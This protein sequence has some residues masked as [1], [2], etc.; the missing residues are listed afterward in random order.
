VRWRLFS[1]RDGRKGLALITAIEAEADLRAGEL[2]DAMAVLP[3]DHPDRPVLRARAIEAWMPMA[4][5]LTRRYAHRGENFDDLVQ[6][7]AIGLIKAI[8]GFDPER[9]SDF[10]GY[11]I[12]TILGEVK[13]YFR[14]RSWSLRIP[15]RLQELR[16]RINAAKGELGH[17]LGRSAT[18]ADLS[19]HL[20][21][22]EELILEALEAGYAY[23]ADSLSAPVGDES[24]ITL[25]DTLRIEEHGYELTEI[26]VV[27]PRAMACLTEREQRIVTMSFYGN[28]TQTVIAEQIGVSQMHVSRLLAGA[29]RK[30]RTQLG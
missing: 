16:L 17:A 18:V 23:R 15:R 5:R 20:E 22:S 3:L 19:E 8:D 24:G 6:T 9:G 30:L 21:V 25:G 29:L 26:N 11:A 27:L 7:A 14:D 4:R 13:R 1:F 12:P 10:V 28:M 2:I